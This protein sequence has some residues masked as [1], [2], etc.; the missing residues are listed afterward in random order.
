MHAG[1]Q[2]NETYPYVRKERLRP[3][4]SSQ[5][6]LNNPCLTD[7]F[8][9]AIFCDTTLSIE[10]RV[11]DIIDRL[12]WEEKVDIVGDQM[13]PNIPSLGLNN[14]SWWNEAST[15]VATSDSDDTPTTKFAFPITTGMSFNRSLW[16]T[17]G[18]HIGREARALMNDG[19]LFS[20]FWAPVVNLAR[21]PRWGRNIEVPSEDPYQSS[22]Y[23]VEFVTGF[24][25]APEDPDHV[26][27][28]ACCKH[29]IANEM[30]DTTE[31]AQH[32]DRNHVD[33]AVSQ[34]DL[35]DS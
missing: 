21:E 35:M 25:E 12:S 11:Q 6:L 10:V 1:Q 28:S 15:G 8:A 2:P 4:T 18:T 33:S 22:Q 19:K 29:F 20:T 23:A 27:A 14:Y 9:D 17:T 32:N 7:E 31:V 5:P 3:D 34:Q 16:H 24:Q 30:E 13:Q 26:Q